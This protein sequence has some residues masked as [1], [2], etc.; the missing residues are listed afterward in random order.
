MPGGTG[1]LWHHGPGIL[2]TEIPA[3]F[4]GLVEMLPPVCESDLLAVGALLLANARAPCS[5]TP[6]PCIRVSWALRDRRHR[7]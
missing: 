6:A 2:P 7:G 1:R 5:P 3:I 4:L